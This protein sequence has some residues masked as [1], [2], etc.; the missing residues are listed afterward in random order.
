MMYKADRRRST[1]RIR[2]QKNMRS[3]GVRLLSQVLLLGTMAA[4]V[5]GVEDLLEKIHRLSREGFSH[6]EV[7]RPPH[8]KIVLHAWQALP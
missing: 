4:D 7:F 1:V 2:A 8:A 6:V 5:V 3:F